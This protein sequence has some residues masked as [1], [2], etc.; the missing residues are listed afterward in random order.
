[1]SK[2]Q[3]KSPIDLPKVGFFFGPEE[4]FLDST[5]FFLFTT[6]SGVK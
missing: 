5:N 4:N 1:M 2:S 3:R 6:K